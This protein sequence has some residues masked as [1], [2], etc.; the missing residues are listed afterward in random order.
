[1]Y[2]HTHTLPGHSKLAS[3]KQTW[4]SGPWAQW[5]KPFRKPHSILGCS[6]AQNFSPRLSY[7]FGSVT[8]RSVTLSRNENWRSCRKRPQ[9]VLLDKEI[10]QPQ[11]LRKGK[12][13]QQFAAADSLCEWYIVTR[14]FYLCSFIPPLSLLFLLFFPFILFCSIYC[15]QHHHG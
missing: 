10:H 12:K 13:E 9:T 8:I 4:N 15:P 6:E 2:T 1:M 11:T 3:H 14:A 7:L 5:K